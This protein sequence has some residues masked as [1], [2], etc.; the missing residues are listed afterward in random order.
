MNRDRMRRLN[1]VVIVIVALVLASVFASDAVTSALLFLAIVVAL[2]MAHEAAHFVTAKI[3]GVRV[4]EFGVGFPPRIAGKRFG[5]TDYTVNW[6]PLGG[7]VKL[8][9]EEDP[10]DPRSLAAQAAWKRLIILASGSVVNLLLPILLFAIAYTIPHEESISRAVI[11]TVVPGSPAAAAGLQPED[12]IVEIDG[13]DAKNVFETGK[14]IRLNLGNDTEIVVNRAGELVTVEVMPRWSPPSGEGPT[15][16]TIRSQCTVVGGQG[17][18][19]FSETVSLYPWESFPKGL[20]ATIDSII[21]ARNDVISWFKG[22]SGPEVAGPV[23]IAQTTGEV[24]REEGFAT[25]VA[26][27]AILSLNLGVLN[28]LPVPMLD[29]GRMLFVFIEIV[30]GGRRIAPEKEALVHFVGLVLFIALAIVVTF[31]DIL[32]LFEGDTVPR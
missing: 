4:L 22:S 27:A 16:I 29:G 32:R 28:L 9:G 25:V 21:L 3:F 19:P 24:A 15:G 18:V 6:L 17:C 13:R 8:L 2:V 26:L 7:F 31:G 30:R 10:G 5:E 11:E 14:L 20:Q 12:V 1:R 23:G